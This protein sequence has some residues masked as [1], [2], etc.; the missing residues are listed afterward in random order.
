MNE[1]GGDA[2]ENSKYYQMRWTIAMTAMVHVGSTATYILRLFNNKC[3]L[4]SLS[5]GY[6]YLF[7]RLPAILIHILCSWRPRTNERKQVNEQK[8]IDS[9]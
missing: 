4:N 7:K 2:L 1:K 6:F 5:L 3:R 8:I 9:N